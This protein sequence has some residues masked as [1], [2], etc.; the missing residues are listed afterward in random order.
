MFR[1]PVPSLSLGLRYSLHF[2]RSYRLRPP[3]LLFVLAAL[4]GCS[5]TEP[6]NPPL[7]D[8][9]PEC[10]ALCSDVCRRPRLP[11]LLRARSLHCRVRDDV[12]RKRHGRERRS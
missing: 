6:S 11:R 7:A 8:V 10:S 12:P 3:I 9:P 2:T 1:M 5:G 4:V